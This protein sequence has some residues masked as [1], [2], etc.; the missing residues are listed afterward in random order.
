[1][2][3]CSDVSKVF[4]KLKQKSWVNTS[5]HSI[6]YLETL[7]GRYEGIN[8]LEGFR[9][10]TETL[11]NEN[12][13]SDLLQHPFYQM[14]VSDNKIIFETRQPGL[15]DPSSFVV[16]Y[17]L[18]WPSRP[19]RLLR[20]LYFL[21]LV[22][23]FKLYDGF[24]LTITNQY[25]AHTSFLSIFYPHLT[26]SSAGKLFQSRSS[27]ELEFFNLKSKKIKQHSVLTIICC[28]GHYK[29]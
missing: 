7:N 22:W 20:Q 26:K 23:L 5:V 3:Q 12:L 8:V 16:F 21:R 19:F 29:L 10:N 9:S 2:D 4:S 1:M 6:L 25:I 28:F 17:I 27:A 13:T 15:M 11:C 24:Y 14:C 18:I